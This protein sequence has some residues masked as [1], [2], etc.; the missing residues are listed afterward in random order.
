MVLDRLKLKFEVEIHSWRF[1]PIMGHP[2]NCDF[3]FEIHFGRPSKFH[4]LIDLKIS[5]KRFEVTFSTK[6]NKYIKF[7]N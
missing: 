1:G 7:W 3:C 5:A 4:F 6:N 2:R